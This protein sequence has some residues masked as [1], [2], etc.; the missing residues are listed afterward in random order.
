MM[1]NKGLFL[2]LLFIPFYFFA[3]ELSEKEYFGVITNIISDAEKIP[4]ISFEGK[5]ENAQINER[6]FN[7]STILTDENQRVELALYCE[8]EQV[9]L[10][11]V[12]DNT[13]VRISYDNSNN[14]QSFY[15]NYGRIR[16]VSAKSIVTDIESK[17]VL[18]RNYGGD[19]GLIILANDKGI[20]NGNFIVFDG[21]ASINS[22]INTGNNHVIKPLEYV[23]IENGEIYPPEEI[24]N[25]IVFDWKETSKALSPDISPSL[26]LVLEDIDTT[27]IPKEEDQTSD[28]KV[29]NGFN[30][31]KFLSNFL[32]FEIGSI[33][34]D[35]NIGVKFVHKPGFSVLDNKLEFRFYLPVNFIPSKIFT[36]DAFFRVNRYNNEWTF[37]FDQNGV[38]QAIV[39]DA[40][41]DLLLKVEKIRFNTPDDLFFL[42]FGLYHDVSDFNDYSMVG[43]NSRIF[44]PKL[45]KPSLFS[46][47]KTKWFE[48]FIYAEDALP[49]GLYGTDLIFM[50]PRQSFK[51]KYRISAFADCYDMISTYNGETFTLFQANS[52]LNFDAF[53][54]SSF[55]FSIYLSG[56]ML[57]PFS[58]N[59]TTGESLFNQ[60]IAANSSALA[61]GI[62]A[63]TGFLIRLYKLS[64]FSEFIFD[65]GLNKI[66]L[67][68]SLY[69]AQRENHVSMIT[70]W[71][72][73]MIER[74]VSIYDYNFGLRIRFKYNLL[75]HVLFNTAY[76]ITV[77]AYYDKFYF[78][79]V[80]DSLDKW[81]VNLAFYTEWVISKIVLGIISYRDLQ[82]NNVFYL[83][84]KIS[85]Y[86]GFDIN[87]A[88]GIYPDFDTYIDPWY[89]KFL[90]DFS[91]AIRPDE[92]LFDLKNKK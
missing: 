43:F 44:Y 65:S 46:S 54:V 27:V 52:T 88:G 31:K 47:I 23:Y 64:F 56:G 33:N 89:S 78:K 66:G 77:P 34:Y 9:G 68:D 48:G 81:K 1:K 3:Q 18:S 39:F 58:Y 41:D 80:L 6:V 12:G 15:I 76:Q 61:T 17:T 63:E 19:F 71:M 75:K 69:I 62:S 32:S 73:T 67:F 10:L 60:M 7:N 53:N 24:G 90:F 79:L 37:G 51:I 36:K 82:E 29:K 26:T 28:K 91:I 35:R 8:D 59:P 42:Q 45:R 83:G 50:S 13:D 86:K 70:T 87:L 20:N 57:V 11:V 25:R 21:E 22:K 40:I 4:Q 30:Y 72:N 14:Q 16:V 49:K 84:F 2:I 5:L 38:V 85:P 74:P 92:S 55:G